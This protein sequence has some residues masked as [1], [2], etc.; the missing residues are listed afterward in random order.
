MWFNI[1][2]VKTFKKQYSFVRMKLAFG[3]DRAYN[4][5]I[6]VPKFILFK[7]KVIVVNKN[8]ITD[9]TNDD[10]VVLFFASR[11]IEIIIFN[12]L[13]VENSAWYDTIHDFS[14]SGDVINFGARL[15]NLLLL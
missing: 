7:T 6:K 5:M 10:N 3:K 8:I 12:L 15:E 11:L 1:F 14:L 2:K 13:I 4:P 9:S